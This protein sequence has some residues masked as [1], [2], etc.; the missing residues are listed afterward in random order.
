MA[1]IL[2]LAL[3]ALLSQHV[4]VL[5]IA[6]WGAETSLTLRHALGFPKGTVPRQSTLQRLFAKLDPEGLIGALR[7]ACALTVPVPTT[8][9]S[10]GVALDGKAQ[11]GRRAADPAAGVVHAL[12]AFCHDYGIVLSQAP[13]EHAGAKA[14]AELTVAPEVIASLDWHNRVLTGDALFCQRA[15]CQQVVD[16]GGDYLLL[17][18]ENQ[19]TLF[20]AIRLLFAPP[21]PA[22]PLTDR[23]EATTIDQGHGRKDD[24]RRLIASTDLAGYLDW[25][26]HAQVFRLERTWTEKG[27]AHYVVRYGITSLPPP[28]ADAARLLAIKRA[29]WQIENRLHRPKDVTLAEDAS[30][31]HRDHGPDILAILR[32]LAISLL[33]AGGIQT[34]AAQLRHFSAHPEEVVSFVLGFSP[35]N[36]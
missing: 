4:C 29:H 30:L 33:H 1:S 7:R 18:K 17:V 19:P 15:L 11:R 6:Q 35:Q 21:D 13:I 28:V 31:V 16:G 9:G 27:K 3:V 26:G 5:G 8:R 12:N 32:N 23:R 22:A 25:P 34:I 24:T 2:A 36:A 20:A 10:Q 14:E